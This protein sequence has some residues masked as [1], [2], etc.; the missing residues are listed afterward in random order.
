VAGIEAAEAFEQCADPEARAVLERIASEETR[1]AELAWRFVAWALESTAEPQRT[2]LRRRIRA[3][4]AEELT[5]PVSAGE[6]GT[7]DRELAQHGLLRPALRQALR[8]RVLREVV[9][10]CADALIG[11]APPA[12]VQQARLVDVDIERQRTAAVEQAGIGARQVVAG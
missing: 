10:P 11:S 12:A 7:L 4:L 5:A 3:A 9:A 1:H 2:E 8:G 6:I